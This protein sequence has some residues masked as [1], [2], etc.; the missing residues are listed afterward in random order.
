MHRYNT[1]LLAIQ[2]LDKYNSIQWEDTFG[3]TDFIIE[4]GNLDSIL[5][6]KHTKYI[7][8]DYLS[9]EYPL[10]K[11]F[12]AITSIGGFS[13]HNQGKIEAQQK[14]VTLTTI[15]IPL[16]NDSF[17]TNRCSID[18]NEKLPS[19]ESV[20]PNK[21]IFFIEE[22]SKFGIKESIN[23]IGE[24]IGLYYSTID[25]F[26]KKNTTP[27]NELLNFICQLFRD[28]IN[29]HFQNE[30]LFLKKIIL[31]LVLKNLVMRINNDH[32]IGCG[33]DHFFARVYERKYSFTHGK[34]V[35]L[36]AIVSSLLFPEW[37]QWGIETPTLI[38]NGLSLNI[39]SISD[40]HNIC[41]QDLCLLVNEA[42]NKR[43]ERDSIL[44]YISK[45]NIKTK[46][47]LFKNG[48]YKTNIFDN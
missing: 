12:D 36:G 37:N 11:K 45:E 9:F 46:Q 26:M 39:I 30:K 2:N 8:A 38:K 22:L 3:K 5:K 27:N 48:I 13:V 43:K 6:K 23:G 47:E 31:G 32:E 10:C 40:I 19:F 1:I 4:T 18:D 14:K 33:I 29:A 28:I 16:S 20:Y 21:C 44:R 34:A 42:L 24:Y 15:P 17:G 25:Y 35:Y 7:I 41:S